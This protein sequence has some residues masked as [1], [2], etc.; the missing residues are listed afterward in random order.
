MKYLEQFGHGGDIVTA[1]SLFGIAPE[2]LLDFSANINPLGPP[3]AVLEAV[4]REMRHIVHY[5]DP[6]H[7]EC[8]R[9]LADKYG[10]REGFLII[11]NG[12]AECMS[13]VLL[14]LAPRTVGVTYPSFV[15]YTQ[16][17]RQF[18]A[19]VIGC[20][21]Q[22]E[23]DFLPSLEELRELF[24]RVDVLFIGHPNNPTGIMYS[25]A[26]MQQLAAWAEETNTYMVVDEAFIDFIPEENQPT[27]LPDI[28]EYPHVILLRSLTKFYAIPG[29]RLGFAVAHPA[30]IEKMKA[31]QVPWS[32]N[33]LALA[34]GEACCH[35]PDYETATR[36]LIAEERNYLMQTLR[37]KQGWHVWSGQA[38]FLLVR[39]PEAMTAFCLQRSLGMRG[40]MIR[41]CAM[42]PGLT[43]RDFRIAVRS[44]HENEQLLKA[45]EEVMGE[46]EMR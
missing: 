21:G 28:E 44:R 35:V 42:Y 22:A 45:I 23:H 3:E 7:R 17:A 9:A 46:E 20:T 2:A 31:K 33:R 16:L 6:A 15:E 38:N 39:L 40:I 19:D 12:A 41:N 5:P 13:L 29:L 32:V 37:G 8:A 14:A 36:Q 18:G 24:D 27:L 25:E 34:A 11:G 10:I 1:S 26:E 4:E 43:A 30:I